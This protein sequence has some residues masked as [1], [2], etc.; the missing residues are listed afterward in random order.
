MNFNH[1]RKA[2]YPIDSGITLSKTWYRS[3]C[4]IYAWHARGQ[5]FCGFS[6][7][8]FLAIHCL[9]CICDVASYFI[10]SVEWGGS[11][12]VGS[13]GLPLWQQ[14]NAA[15]L[16]VLS[17][18]KFTLSKHCCWM[19]W[20]SS[21]S[22]TALFQIILANTLWAYSLKKN[23]CLPSTATLSAVLLLGSLAHW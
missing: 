16:I 18:L 11:A 21:C 7:C 15:S 4:V 19:Y 17:F 10:I 22:Y 13:N 1:L 9:F 3:H 23:S 8:M 2:A 12:P 6:W 5:P 14:F 20:S